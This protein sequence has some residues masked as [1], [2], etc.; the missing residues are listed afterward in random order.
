MR[1]HPGLVRGQFRARRAQ[2]PHPD[3]DVLALRD[4]QRPPQVVRQAGDLGFGDAGERVVLEAVGDVGRGERRHGLAGTGR[5]SQALVYRLSQQPRRLQAGRHEDVDLGRVMPVE[6]GRREARVLRDLPVRHAGEAVPREQRD[7]RREDLAPAGARHG[8][9][10]EFD[11]AC[12]VPGCPGIGRGHA[13]RR[14]EQHVLDAAPG[15]GGVIRRDGPD[16]AEGRRRPQVR[17]GGRVLAP[18]GV[19]HPADDVREFRPEDPAVLPAEVTR[20]PPVEPA[21]RAVGDRDPDEGGEHVRQHRTV[22]R[23]VDRRDETTDGHVR[24]LGE[25]RVLVREVPVQGRR[26]D[27]HA[28]GDLLHGRRVITAFAE[29]LAGRFHDQVLAVAGPRP[30]CRAVRDGHLNIIGTGTGGRRRR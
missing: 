28:R 11:G 20:L 16:R 19:F 10:R 4:D 15:D 23:L 14:L 25:Q 13:R 22:G 30:D 2:L 1:Q 5:V 8:R 24:A 12:V 17:A 7:S 26:R 27:A 6:R 3:A 29:C 9:G 21:R 18:H